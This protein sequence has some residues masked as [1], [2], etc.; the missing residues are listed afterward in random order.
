MKASS[1]PSRVESQQALANLCFWWLEEEEEEEDSAGDVSAAGECVLGS[2]CRICGD[3]VSL[4]KPRQGHK[5]F[6]TFSGR[7]AEIL[8][9]HG[10]GASAFGARGC[11][12]V[13][14]DLRYSRGISAD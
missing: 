11:V 9:G 6:T 14:M 7:R 5:A 8:W 10:A 1:W 2:A 3:V 4:Q 13:S 12:G